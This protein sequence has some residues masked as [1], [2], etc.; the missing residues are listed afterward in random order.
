MI[1]QQFILDAFCKQSSA[2]I[3]TD[4]FSLAVISMPVT[5]IG[6]H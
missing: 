1:S 6:V 3:A 5:Q 2:L 4:L